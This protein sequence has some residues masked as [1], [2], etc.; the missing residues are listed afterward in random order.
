MAWNNSYLLLRGSPQVK[1]RIGSNCAMFVG[2]RA[3]VYA[4]ADQF[5]KRKKLCFRV[6]VF[7][8]F[9]TE[10][11]PASCRHTPCR[12]LQEARRRCCSTM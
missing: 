6:F 8:C 11:S 12:R 3:Y 9:R 7:S 1:H 4:H 10:L 2:S 5:S